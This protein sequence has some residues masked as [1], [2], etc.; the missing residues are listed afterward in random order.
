[1]HE[2]VETKA[3]NIPN[4]EA[5]CAWDVTLTYVESNV[6]LDVVAR[7][8]NHI[9]GPAWHVCSI[10]VREE[11]VDRRGNPRNPQSWRSIRSPKPKRSI[12]ETCWNIANCEC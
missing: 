1:M 12:R 6:L 5:I 3:Q 4:A 8:L 11:H 10:C 2:L 9:G 7:R